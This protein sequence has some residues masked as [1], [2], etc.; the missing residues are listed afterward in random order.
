[1]SAVSFDEPVEPRHGTRE[2]LLATTSLVA[3]CAITSLRTN[4]ATWEHGSSLDVKHAEPRFSGATTDMNA[5]VLVA[6]RRPYTFVVLAILILLFGAISVFKTPTRYLSDSAPLQGGT[7]AST[8]GPDYRDG[9]WR[10]E[11]CGAHCPDFTEC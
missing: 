11:W 3:Q 8:M 1:M 7:I 5:I 4:L 6:L 2:S 9:L 10:S